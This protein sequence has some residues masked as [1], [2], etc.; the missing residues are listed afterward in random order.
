MGASEFEVFLHLFA[1]LRE[2]PVLG[3]V[4]GIGHGDHQRFMWPGFGV[5]RLVAST[6]VKVMV[7]P[8]GD[9]L[10]CIRGWLPAPQ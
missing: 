3:V 8:S 4:V 5:A 6:K 9:R 10:A 1:I 7:F 2:G